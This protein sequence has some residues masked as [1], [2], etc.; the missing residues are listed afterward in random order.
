MKKLLILSVFAALLLT[1]CGAESTE[2]TGTQNEEK[3]EQTNADI[4]LDA[5]IYAQATIAN[6]LE[7]CDLIQNKETKTECKDVVQANLLT[8]EAREK[9]DTKL[10]ADIKLERYKEN[11]EFM[12]NAK[13]EKADEQKKNQERI[14]TESGL[15]EKLISEGNIKKCDQLKDPN[16]LEQCK[17]QIVINKAIAAN[18]VSKCNELKDSKQAEFCK[19][20]I[21]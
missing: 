12:V 1:A 10:C 21:R 7:Q 14:I 17:L 15:V 20:M 3:N 19:Q 8:M 9:M 11:C 2:E 6:N 13:V 18:D 4:A 5:N 16:Y